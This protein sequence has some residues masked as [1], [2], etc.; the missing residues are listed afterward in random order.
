MGTTW[1]RHGMCELAF[2]D[3]PRRVCV[4]VCVVSVDWRW[5]VRNGL[6]GVDSSLYWSGVT[7][8]NI[9]LTAIGLSPGGSGHLTHIQNTK[10]VCY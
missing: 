9:L 3:I 1:K 4:T 2:I 6:L 8:N 10:Q 7:N 5:A